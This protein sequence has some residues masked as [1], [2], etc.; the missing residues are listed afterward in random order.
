MIEPLLEAERLLAVGLLDQAEQRFAQIAEADPRNSIAVVGLARVALERGDD[1]DA[2]AHAKRAA[3]IDPEN[4]VAAGMIARLEEIAGIRAGSPPAPEVVAPPASTAAEP[5][6]PV[7]PTAGTRS[8]PAPLG[9]APSDP[10]PSG[11]APQGPAPPGTAPPG[12]SKVVAADPTER[13]RPMPDPDEIRPPPSVP[14]PRSS[15][16][17]AADLRRPVPPAPRRRR[18]GL[19]RRILGR[20]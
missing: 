19:L 15:D 5:P 1:A 18:R 14:T 2:L 12:P 10:A 13:A 7:T 9:T 4:P 3:L 6:A 16:H 8:D 17:V 20:D 11:T